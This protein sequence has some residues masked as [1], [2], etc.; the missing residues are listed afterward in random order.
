MTKFSVML[1][2][3]PTLCWHTVNNTQGKLADVQIIDT[4]IENRLMCFNSIV[5]QLLSKWFVL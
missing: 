3:I 4:V 1:G 5:S 2:I